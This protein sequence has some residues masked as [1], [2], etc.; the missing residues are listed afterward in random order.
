ML[1]ARVVKKDLSMIRKGG[2]RFSEEMMLKYRNG[3][4]NQKG[5]IS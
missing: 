2:Y 1:E 4:H 5:R 3:R